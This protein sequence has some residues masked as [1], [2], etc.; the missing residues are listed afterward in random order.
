MFLDDAFALV[1][2]DLSN[3]LENEVMLLLRQQS[4]GIHGTRGNEGRE[5]GEY[6]RWGQF[7]F[8][9]YLLNAL[10]LTEE[11]EGNETRRI[12][13]LPFLFFPLSRV[14]LHGIENSLL[15]IFDSTFASE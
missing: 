10:A 6:R 2:T 12:G 11:G 14:A 7:P 3:D 5:M 13:T 8:F 9:R 15:L 4:A 1:G